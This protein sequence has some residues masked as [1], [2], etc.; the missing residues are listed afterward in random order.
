MSPSRPVADAA[1]DTPAMFGPIIASLGRDAVEHFGAA[2]VRLVPLAYE[3]RPFSHLLRL[4]VESHA[5]TTPTHIFIKIFKPKADEGGVAAMRQRVAHEFET[6]KRIHAAMSAWDGLGT[7]RPIACD[8]DQLAMVTE[9]AEGE[10]LLAHLRSRAAW[11]PSAATRHRL[12]ETMARV[13]RWVRAFQT[14]DEHAAH[15][16]I[17]SLRH[18]VDLRLM[19]L[20]GRRTEFRE[21]D[22]Y[23]VL[24][25]LDA[26]GSRIQPADLAEVI[27][28][29]DFAAG[30]VL[31]AE[32]RIVVLDFAMTGR[33]T[34]LHDI[35]RL[36]MQLDL[37]R[38]KPQF[39]GR[40][41][42][43]LQ[44]GLLRGFDP[45]LTPDHPLFRFLLMLHHINHF[46]TVSL[47]RKRSLR[48]V[49]NGRLRRI[50][51]RWIQRELDRGSARS[52]GPR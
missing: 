23:R 25:Y 15:V 31:V 21:S 5:A 10:T 47:Q 29:A 28:H 38:A 46:G 14:L 3:E 40:S 6:T 8:L 16:P 48:G 41:I 44:G 26:L 1:R 24:D 22:R 4:R 42:R 7:A 18:Y 52:E 45:S 49:F 35:S 27:V 11:F 2:E 37:L 17:A 34:R 12:D 30:N 51:W 20:V 33:G 13:G 19:R 39:R 50:H 9:Q 32:S 36:F 43:A